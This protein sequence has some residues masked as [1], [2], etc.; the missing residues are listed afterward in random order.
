VAEPR[1]LGPAEGG[2]V[3]MASSWRTDPVG[4][5]DAQRGPLPL[6][7]AE[8]GEGV[9]SQT[10]VWGGLLDSI[11][12]IDCKVMS[13]LAP[14]DSLL[15]HHIG[16]ESARQSRRGGQ[17]GNV[18]ESEE[19][20][21]RDN[22]DEAG[23]G[24][25]GGRSCAGTGARAHSPGSCTPLSAISGGG[26]SRCESRWSEGSIDSRDSL[27]G[28]YLSTLTPNLTEVTEG[29]GAVECKLSPSVES[30]WQREAIRQK[31]EMC[32]CVCVR[33]TFRIGFNTHIRYAQRWRC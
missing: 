2:A 26:L 23:G 6:T 7:V 13:D 1:Q 15:S 33:L 22:G 12:S 11:D 28:Y 30:K 19:K 25:Q 21:A 32:M 4:R 29:R 27:S 20:T 10:G 9:G 18:I 8:M 14:S 24:G 5:H 31:V 16:R 3:V 17:G